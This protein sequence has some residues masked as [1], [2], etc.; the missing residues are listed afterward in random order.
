MVA[1]FAHQIQYEYNG[2]N[3]YVYIEGIALENFSPA[4]NISRCLYQYPTDDMLCFIQ[5]FNHRKQY[6]ATTS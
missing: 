5:F 4:E 3:I 6:V 2:G 1:S